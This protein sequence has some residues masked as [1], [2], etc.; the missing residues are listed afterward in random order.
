[1]A[2]PYELSAAFS[3][4]LVY[5]AADAHPNWERSGKGV[6]RLRPARRG[7]RSPNGLVMWFLDAHPDQARLI[8]AQEEAKTAHLH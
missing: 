4:E 2:K 6:K 7:P 8:L 5:A 1:M 3:I